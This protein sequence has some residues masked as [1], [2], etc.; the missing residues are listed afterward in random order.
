MDLDKKY[1]DEQTN[2]ERIKE[3]RLLILNDK[4]LTQAEKDELIKQ[5]ES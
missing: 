3:V 4:K 5:L 1:P 2:E